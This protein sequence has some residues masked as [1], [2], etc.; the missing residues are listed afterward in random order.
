MLEPVRLVLMRMMPAART[1]MKIMMTR[2]MTVF[3]FLMAIH[4]RV[5]PRIFCE[6]SESSSTS[7]V[8][9]RH[10]RLQ[11]SHTSLKSQAFSYLAPVRVGDESGE[12]LDLLGAHPALDNLC[13][14]IRDVEE[15][16]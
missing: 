2:T 6:P 14:S 1:K 8:F 7:L 9:K 13:N 16:D 3:S 12:G 4:L 10:G 11:Y 15:L 5:N